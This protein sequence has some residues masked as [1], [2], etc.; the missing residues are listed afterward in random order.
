MS[1]APPVTTS[2]LSFVQGQ[3]IGN[4][5]IG[6]VGNG[7][8]GAIAGAGS[9]GSQQFDDIARNLF[10][11]AD[12]VSVT[13][14]VHRF[15]FGGWAQKVQSNDN[16]ADQRNGVASFTDLQHFMQGSA[17]QV[18]ATLNP[19]GLG[20]RQN[21]GAWYAQDT[22]QLRRNLTLTLGVRHEFNNGWNSAYGNAANFV[23]GPNGILLTQPVVGNS[24][25]STNNAKYMIGPRAGLAWSPFHGSR[26]A[27]HAGY[28][29]Y[30]EQLDYMGACCDSIPIGAYNNRVTV[31]PATFPILFAP[32]QTLPG[33]KIGP[34]GV[35]PDLKMPAVFQYSL[36]VDQS[37]TANTLLSVGYVGERGYHLLA[38]SD[39]NTAIPTMV[40]NQPYFAPKSPRANPNL[41]NARYQVSVAASNYNALQIDLTHRYSH[42]LQFRLNYTFSKSLDNHSSSFLANSGVGGTTTFLDPRNPNL[43]WGPSNF[44]IESRISGNLGYELPIGKGKAVLG[45][46]GRIPDAIFGGWQINAIVGAQTGFSVTPLVGFNQSA[47][48]DSRNPDRVSL[49][50]NFS[51]NIITGTPGQWFNPAA[52]LLPAAGTF[53]D[54]GRGILSAPG[55][56]SV[57]GS[58]FKTFRFGER[59]TLQFRAEFFNAPNHTNFGW[60]VISTFTSAGAVSSSAGVI[61]S[62]LSTSRQ[63]QFGLKLG[64]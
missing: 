50:P 32:G 43:D 55:L 42:G 49:N 48:G 40:N 8:I 2:S 7:Q 18:V 33:S 41:S 16:A 51:G 53:G 52:F 24:V 36:R 10:T 54:A 28:G 58:M 25:Y 1:T 46:A 14:G 20:W 6:S 15:E 12:T 47:N 4:I 5:N 45:S 3:P 35:D 59:A 11:V 13:K 27:I 37:V 26:T 63:L 9:N 17:T 30:Y 64:W 61:T 19:I 57:D 29:L 44:N 38:P 22:L 31:S 56:L 23:P 39:V 62:T 21:A 34:T 60:P